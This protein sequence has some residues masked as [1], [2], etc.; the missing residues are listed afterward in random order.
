VVLLCALLV[1]VLL[2]VAQIIYDAHKTKQTISH[3]AQ[4]VLAMFRDPSTQAIYSL[5]REM[6][7]QVIEGLLQHEAVRHASIGHP[8]DPVLAENS[9]PPLQI[10]SRWLTDLILGTEA[11]F[12]I[13]L[14]GRGPYSE[15]YGD[16]HLTLDTAPYGE[17]WLLNSLI[18]FVSG[19]LRALALAL[20]LYLIYHWMLT[21]P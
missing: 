16:L 17:D 4:R 20:V 21:K 1:G 11:S 6:G 12:S 13:P 7:M 3:D 10:D 15:H 2:S 18:I 19:V 14:V 9:R 5:D 8:D